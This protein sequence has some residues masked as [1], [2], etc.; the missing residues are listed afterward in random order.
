MKNTIGVV[1][2]FFMVLYHSS[3][4]GSPEYNLQKEQDVLSQLA[5]DAMESGDL[6][7]VDQKMEELEKTDTDKGLIRLYRKIRNTIIKGRKWKAS[8]P[9]ETRAFLA[10]A[11]KLKR[12]FKN[13]A[14]FRANIVARTH[15]CSAVPKRFSAQCSRENMD[16]LATIAKEEMGDPRFVS[17]KDFTSNSASCYSKIGETDSGYPSMHAVLFGFMECSG[18]D[19]PFDVYTFG[20]GVDISLNNYLYMACSGSEPASEM[21]A[22]GPYFKVD[23]LFGGVGFGTLV[24]DSGVCVLLQTSLVGLGGIAG[25]VYLE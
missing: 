21:S 6:S 2:A 19:T 16:V 3:A 5:T 13:D 4:Y 18:G 9:E 25:L 15:D 10:Q 8:H 23:A 20:P 11:A 14:S 12:K 7:Q 22:F 1:I 17:K 24:G